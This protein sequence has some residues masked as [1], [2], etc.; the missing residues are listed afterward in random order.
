VR[1]GKT[2]S[3]DSRASPCPVGHTVAHEFAE[4]S[5]Q[6]TTNLAEPAPCLGRSEQPPTC[7][8][9]VAQFS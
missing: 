2:M 9:G 4:A 1:G 5:A 6:K 3:G 7:P 8:Q